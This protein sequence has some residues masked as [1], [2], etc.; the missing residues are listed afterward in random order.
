MLPRRAAD[1]RKKSRSPCKSS[2]TVN[3]FTSIHDSRFGVSVLKR[4]CAWSPHEPAGPERLIF[5]VVAVDL[6]SAQTASGIHD[7]P[8]IAAEYLLHVRRLSLDN[9]AV[10]QTILSRLYRSGKTW[11]QNPTATGCV[12][13]E[14]I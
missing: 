10:P 5:S 11:D 14:R 6:P 8:A 2:R 12:R 1:R 7:F 9:G 13:S 3:G 4:S